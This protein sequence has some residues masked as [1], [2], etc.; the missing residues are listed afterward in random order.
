[1]E[2]REQGFTFALAINQQIKIIGNSAAHK[3]Q[4]AFF[5]ATINQKRCEAYEQASRSHFDHSHTFWRKCV[6]PRNYPFRILKR[7]DAGTTLTEVAPF[8]LDT[9]QLGGVG[10]DAGFVFEIR[11]HV[12]S[13]F[14]L[15]L[16]FRRHS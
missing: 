14:E 4:D 13:R 9:D 3:C 16:K 8:I 5:T 10:K 12:L 1:M 15:R 2:D 7:S 11:S 6:S